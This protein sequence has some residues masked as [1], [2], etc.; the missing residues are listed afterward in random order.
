MLNTTEALVLA[1]F[2]FLPGA[3]ST[4]TW[5]NVA[6]LRP[7][8]N[9]PERRATFALWSA[10]NGVF[11]LGLWGRLKW[12]LEHAEAG[13]LAWGEIGLLVSVL[14]ALPF[15][16]ALL[17]GL[18]LRLSWLRDRLTAWGVINSRAFTPWDRITS[19]RK[20]PIRIYFKSGKDHY[21]GQAESFD[22]EAQQVLVREVERFDEDR[23]EWV[24]EHGYDGALLFDA[25]R[26]VLW[27]AEYTKNGEA[28]ANDAPYHEG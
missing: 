18:L 28:N 6:D 4:T 7:T 19:W 10:I 2:V 26:H 22:T 1:A 27:F 9:Q 11:V 8:Q 16:L 13:S 12:V 17:P 24:L 21:F 3:V 20:T 23:D 5:R 14:V 15:G 25:G